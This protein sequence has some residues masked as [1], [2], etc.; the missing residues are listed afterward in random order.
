M[1]I[2]AKNKSIDPL[3]SCVVTLNQLNKLEEIVCDSKVSDESYHLPKL[4]N[5]C[6]AAKRDEM[7]GIK[8]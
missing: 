5:F 2:L 8:R 4:G 1:T 6:S 3:P 7:N